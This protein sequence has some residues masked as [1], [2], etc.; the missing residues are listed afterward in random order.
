[1]GAV[2]RLRSSGQVNPEV[3]VNDNSIPSSLSRDRLEADSILS[4]AELIQP[5]QNFSTNLIVI[6]AVSLASVAAFTVFICA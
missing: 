3:A 2:V 1:M 5:R 6:A 4:Q